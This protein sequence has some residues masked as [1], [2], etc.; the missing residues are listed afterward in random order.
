MFAATAAGRDGTEEEPLR[1]EQVSATTFADLMTMIYTV[2]TAEE[3]PTS[4]DG[5]INI[6]RLAHKFQFAN[7]HRVVKKLLPS[8]LSIEQRLHLAITSCDVDEWGETAFSDLVFAADIEDAADG[9][10]LLP[11]S[12]WLRIFRTRMQIVRFR[13]AA[14]MHLCRQH[15]TGAARLWQNSKQPEK[16]SLRP[17]GC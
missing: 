11:E 10:S 6:L 4:V 9:S 7:I 13:Q 8:R 5:Y 12:F 17:K 16:S 15:E 1:L 2:W 3:S 14:R